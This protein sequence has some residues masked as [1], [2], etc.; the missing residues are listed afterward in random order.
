MRNYRMADMP[1]SGP[2]A[3]SED[4][5]PKQDVMPFGVSDL[6]PRSMALNRWRT[7]APVSSGEKVA[8]RNPS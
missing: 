3:A 5:G 7:G 6:V 2:I 4:G 1:I 8:A